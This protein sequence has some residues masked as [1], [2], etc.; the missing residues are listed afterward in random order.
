MLL[1]APV[2]HDCLPSWPNNAFTV[3][4]KKILTGRRLTVS[5]TLD[6]TN[7]KGVHVS[8]TYMN[9]GDGFSPGPVIMTYI[10]NLDT[11]YYPTGVKTTD[12]DLATVPFRRHD[13]RPEWNYGIEPHP[14]P[15]QCNFIAARA[16]NEEGPLF[17]DLLGGVSLGG[18][19]LHVAE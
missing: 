17:V 13:W 11:G 5:S 19:G 12:A 9:Q 15:R 1:V 4:S 6:P 2:S 3:A 18:I 16:L 8:T 7:V 14:P 10:P